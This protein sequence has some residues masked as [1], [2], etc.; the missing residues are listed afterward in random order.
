ML[1]G[2]ACDQDNKDILIELYVRLEQ[3]FRA[4]IYG[5]LAYWIDDK[6]EEVTVS[7]HIG[8]TP[9]ES[10]TKIETIKHMKVPKKYKHTRN[11]P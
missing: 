2:V 4:S 10:Y 1:Y 5:V 6:K 8:P 9:E 11:K 3:A 7:M